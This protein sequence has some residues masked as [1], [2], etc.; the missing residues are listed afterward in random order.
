MTAKRL[1][2]IIENTG[3]LIAASGGKAGGQFKKLQ[4]IF[5]D[6]DQTAQEAL[7]ALQAV[8]DRDKAASRASYVQNFID[9]GLNEEAFNVTLNRL[10]KDKLMD[11]EDVALIAKDYTGT[12]RRLTSRAKAL[13]VIQQIFF[14]RLYQEGKMK[15]VEKY[16]PW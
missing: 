12:A 7:D 14:E 8:I 13:E 6:K 5:A 9:I 15:I 4:Q 3:D 16:K 10:T 11:K 1:R 2:N